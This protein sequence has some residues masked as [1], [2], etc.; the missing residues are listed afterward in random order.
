MSTLIMELMRA[1]KDLAAFEYGIE[2]NDQIIMSGSL[3]LNA[4]AG[5]AL[6]PLNDQVVPYD[7]VTTQTASEGQEPEHD[8]TLHASILELFGTLA[9]RMRVA[10]LKR[11]QD[12]LSAETDKDAR[13]E[14]RVEAVREAASSLSTGGLV[15]ALRQTITT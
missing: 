8:D 12:S 1:E 2:Y 14:K 13:K 9:E 7:M 6:I 5:T 15:A 4:D 3:E 11:L 10:D